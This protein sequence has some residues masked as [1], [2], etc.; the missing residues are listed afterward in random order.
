[1]MQY[2]SALF[3]QVCIVLMCGALGWLAAIRVSLWPRMWPKAGRGWPAPD[4]ATL[5]FATIMAAPVLAAM[6]VMP[7]RAGQGWL[8]LGFAVIAASAAGQDYRRGLLPDPETIVLAILGAV[9]ATDQPQGLWPALMAAMIGAAV[10]AGLIWAWRWSGRDRDAMGWG[11]V[12]LIAA[13]ALWVGPGGLGPVIA[14]AALAGL[15]VAV[16]PPRTDRL[17]FGPYLIGATWCVVLAKA[18]DIAPLVA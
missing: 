4:R 3:W 7:L 1:M 18:L 14:L 9:F 5:I 11:D 15:A 16:W 13:L 6:T 8:L 12:K 2:D 17:R 10:F